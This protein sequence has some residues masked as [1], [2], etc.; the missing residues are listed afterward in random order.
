MRTPIKLITLMS[1]G[2][3]VFDL[4]DEFN[5]DLAAGSVTGTGATPGPGTRTVTDTENKLAIASSTLTINKKATPAWGD[6]ALFYDATARV[7]GKLLIV[8]FNFSQSGS[9]GSVNIGWGIDTAAAILK[10]NSIYVGSANGLAIYDNNS[11]DFIAHG[12]N[13]S[14]NTNYYLAISLRATGAFYYIKG[15]TFTNWTLFWISNLNSTATLYPAL[16]NKNGIYTSDLVHIP[17]PRWL[18]TPLISDGFGSAGVSDGLGHAEGIAASVGS[19][20]AGKTWAGAT[21]S[22]ASGAALNTPVPGAELAT[23]ALTVGTWYLI[24][25]TEGNHFYADCAVGDTFRAAD[26]TG[27]DAN[28]KVKALT[29][30]ELMYTT[31]LSTADGYF[32][33]TTPAYDATLSQAGYALRVDNPA[34]PQNFIL[35]YQTGALI[36]VVEC[37]SGTY[38]ADLLSATKAFAANR[39]LRV[40]LSGTAVR[41][42]HVTSAGVVT[43][44]GQGTTSITTGT[45]HGLFSTLAAN[46]F[47]NFVAQAKTTTEI[48]EYT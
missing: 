10:A 26:T 43:V 28:N 1:G 22:L 39:V 17:K 32:D 40:D 45:T 24:T 15:G 37:A 6:P 29:L 11:Q 46:T 35:V 21:W 38:S 27:L 19:G 2:G 16:S 14:I 7:V 23:G 34:N 5:T 8:N 12:T 41:V 31:D 4:N 44:V 20:G 13:L 47:D 9:G 36:K 42:Y 25:A 30:S 3:L 48:D 18:P 33:V